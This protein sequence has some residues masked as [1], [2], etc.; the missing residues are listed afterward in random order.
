MILNHVHGYSYQNTGEYLVSFGQISRIYN[1][2]D[3]LIKSLTILGGT[4][5]IEKGGNLLMNSGDIFVAGDWR[6]ID[7]NT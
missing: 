3:I 2:C 1:G 7:K 6:F 4:L 5:I